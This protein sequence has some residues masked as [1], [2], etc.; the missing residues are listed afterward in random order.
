MDELNALV[1]SGATGGYGGKTAFQSIDLTLPS[2]SGMAIVGPNG[3]GKTTFMK[4]IVGLIPLTAGTITVSG[5]DLFKARRNVAYVQQAVN[6]DMSFPVT[7]LDV[8]L[9][10]RYRRIGWFRRPGRSDK[11]AA[12]A[13]LEEVGIADRANDRFGVL[14]GGQRQRVML[15]RSIAQQASVVLLDEPFNNLDITTIEVL[16]G[17]LKS[18]RQRGVTL[19]MSTH[20]LS[21][22]KDI[23]DQVLLM[24]CAQ[25]GFGPPDEVLVP[26]NLR[27]AF[28]GGS[29]T[30]HGDEWIVT[31]G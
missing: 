28:G 26:A 9:M 14:S 17:V 2:G 24:N 16:T 15:A 12:M 4:A 29:I 22:A 11:E 6:I 7:V 21:S 1:C 19:V 8:V 18:M 20:D 30:S 10:S 13:A 5:S 25:F 3:A 23:C 31:T 27:A